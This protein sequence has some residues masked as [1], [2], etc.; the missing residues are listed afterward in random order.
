MPRLHEI[1]DTSLPIDEAF[2]FVAD[3]ANQ[4]L[5]DPNTVTSERIDDGPVGVGAR[6]RLDVR[7]G[8]NVVPMEYR[9]TTWEPGRRVVLAGEGSHVRATDEIRFE[10]TATGTRVDYTADIGLT[11]WMRLVEPF[12]GGALD[13][14]GKNAVAGMQRALDERAKAAGR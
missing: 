14:I 6:Y 11:G 3:F 4:S 12:A 10:P 8:S 9:V 13:K 7:Q 1:V 2:A 5:W